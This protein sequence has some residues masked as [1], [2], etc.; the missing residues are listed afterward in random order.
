MPL[1]KRF[2]G[3]AF[4]PGFFSEE[5][6]SIN[7]GRLDA[8][9]AISSRSMKQIRLFCSRKHDSENLNDSL[10]PRKK[11]DYIQTPS[12]KNLHFFHW[13][14]NSRAGSKPRNQKKLGFCKISV[15]Y[16]F[17][18]PKTERINSSSLPSSS[19]KTRLLK[20]KEK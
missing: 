5:N 3:E 12:L 10:V 8:T 16:N 14:P 20:A 19:L 13:S 4:R 6:P 18:N 7:D 17:P 11:K 15:Q 9:D 1:S 2:Q